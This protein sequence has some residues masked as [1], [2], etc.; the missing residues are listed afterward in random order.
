[1]QVDPHG[2]DGAGDLQLLN[3]LGLDIQST[4]MFKVGVVTTLGGN[5]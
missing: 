4:G 1:M 5:S 3:G 2:T